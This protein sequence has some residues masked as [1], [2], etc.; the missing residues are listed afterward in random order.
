MRGFFVNQELGM[1]MRC[2]SYRAHNPKRHTF[3]LDTSLLTSNDLVWCSYLAPIAAGHPK[4]GKDSRPPEVMV[5][6]HKILL[7][8]AT[9][10]YISLIT[11]YGSSCVPACSSHTQMDTASSNS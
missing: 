11:Y 2:P 4:D 6:P 1:H 10:P 7:L 3:Q 9:C 8:C 5:A